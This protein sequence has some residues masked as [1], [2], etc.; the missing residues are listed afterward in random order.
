MS[1]PSTGSRHAAAPRVTVVV[2]TRNR[3]QLLPRAIDSVLRQTYPHWELVV[4]DDASTDETIE[5]VRSRASLDDRVRCRPLGTRAGAASARNVGIHEARGELVAFLDD[6]DE[7][8]PEKL[9]RQVAALDAAPAGVDLV[10]SAFFESDA[11]GN[12]HVVGEF[13]PR[14]GEAHAVLLRGNILGLSTIVVRRSLLERVGGFDERLP[15]LQDWDLW[16]RLAALTRFAF[17]P[18]PLARIHISPASISTDSSALRSACEIIAAKY[19]LPDALARAELAE[20][21]Y[22][23]AQLLLRHGAVPEARVLI[24]RSLR[25][26]PWPPRRLLMGSLALLDVRAHRWAARAH[27]RLVSRRGR[28]IERSGPTRT[29]G[30][31]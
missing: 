12:E 7:W 24:R 27:E 15:R 20:L 30:P 18:M 16:I 19:R 23:L 26:R 25:R 3:A 11:D 21:Y 17:V 4:V 10:H 28:P 9:E 1:Q 29:G 14:G 13:S 31:A 2:P 8:L 22:A 6:D 5:V